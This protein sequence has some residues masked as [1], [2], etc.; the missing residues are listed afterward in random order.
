MLNTFMASGYAAKPFDPMSG[1][2]CTDEEY[3]LL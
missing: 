3:E 1:K 2:V